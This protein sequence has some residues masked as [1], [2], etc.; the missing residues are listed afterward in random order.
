MKKLFLAFVV[1]CIF[2]SIFIFIKS[3]NTRESRIGPCVAALQ[4]SYCMIVICESGF[5]KKDREVCQD[6]SNPIM[7]KDK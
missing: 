3:R 6:G 4:D 2:I 1:I 5:S 7:I